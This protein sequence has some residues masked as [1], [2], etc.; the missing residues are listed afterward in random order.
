MAISVVIEIGV[1]DFLGLTLLASWD[2]ILVA[3]I[4]R[5]N[6]KVEIL[7]HKTDHHKDALAYGE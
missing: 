1:V 3:R 2:E 6:I 5:C 4:S 7:K